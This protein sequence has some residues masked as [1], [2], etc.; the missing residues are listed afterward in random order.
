VDAAGDAAGGARHERGAG[1]GGVVHA[2]LPRARAHQHVPA[3]ASSSPAAPRAAAEAATA[4]E[5]GHAKTRD[6]SLPA[7][8][9]P[10]AL[11]PCFCLGEERRKATMHRHYQ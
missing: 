5:P 9:E 2:P 11:L 4:P 10:G 3:P 1:L 6:R 7:E 8:M